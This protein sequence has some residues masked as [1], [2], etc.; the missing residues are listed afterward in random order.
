MNDNYLIEVPMIFTLT[1]KLSGVLIWSNKR[2]KKMR[3]IEF[4]PTEF[5][6]PVETGSINT[7][8]HWKTIHFLFFKFG[9]SKL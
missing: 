3:F 2:K 8:I 4:C 1:K 7:D 6:F 5:T 9:E